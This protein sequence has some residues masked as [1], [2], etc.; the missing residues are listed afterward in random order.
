M[1]RLLVKIM[2]NRILN[3]R[4]ICGLDIGAQRIKAGLIKV[5]KDAKI[6]DLLG[7]YE[8]RTLGFKDSSVSDLSELGESIHL[9]IHEL[10][11][12]T[13]TKIKEV[14]LGINGDLVESRSIATAIPLID[15]GSKVITQRDIKRINHQARLLG[16]KVDEE[17]LHDLPQFYHVDDVNS[18]LNPLGLL[19]RKLSVNALM[20]ITHMNRVR[21]I[22]KAVIDTGYD[23]NNIFFDSYAASEITLSDQDRLQGCVFI[24]MGAK[25]TSMLIFRDKVLK[26]FK[27]IHMGG[28]DF[29]QAIAQ[30]LKLPFELAEEIKIAYAGALGTD[31]HLQEEVLVKRESTYIPIKRE[32][33]HQAIE[34]VIARVVDSLRHALQTSGMENQINRGIVM[35][36]GASLLMGFIE[37]IEQDLNSSVRLGKINVNIQKS[38]ANAG[39]YS[40]V[41]GLSYLALKKSLNYSTAD[42]QTPW[43]MRVKNHVRDLYQEYF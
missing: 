4:F 2:L 23:V 19:G 26:F 38:L 35:V 24:D 33:I 40:S 32:V 16:I 27:K 18:A 7:V 1:N 13:G 39:L 9:T 15:R 41:V 34:P 10:A 28:N 36:G 21:N 8:N 25:T 43:T 3:E 6:S 31:Q 22:K 30:E 42:D 29:T 5:S 17:I 20:I 37:R 14:Q 11:K 12:I